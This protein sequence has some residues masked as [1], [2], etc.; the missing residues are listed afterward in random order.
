MEAIEYLI[1]KIAPKYS[2]FPGILGYRL[3]KENGCDVMEFLN[4]SCI[5]GAILRG[6]GR[7]FLYMKDHFKEIHEIE[8][9]IQNEVMLRMLNNAEMSQIKTELVK[10]RIAVN[11]IYSLKCL[12][13]EDKNLWANWVKE[14]Y[15]ERKAKL[16]QWYIEYVLPF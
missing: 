12:K 9:Y 3:Y 5:D 2:Y 1:T 16:H 7:F 8:M 4:S 13:A 11:M 14:L 6:W 15:W 10:L